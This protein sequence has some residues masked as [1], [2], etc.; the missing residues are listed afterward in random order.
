MVS[1]SDPQLVQLQVCANY[2][3]AE[4]AAGILGHMNADLH[5]NQSWWWLP[6]KE[7]VAG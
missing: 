3:T 7:W 4:K 6:R 2:L 1:E 5:I